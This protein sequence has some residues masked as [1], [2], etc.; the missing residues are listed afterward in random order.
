MGGE[1]LL[2]CVLAAS[3]AGGTAGVTWLPRGL[4]RWGGSKLLPLCCVLAAFSVGRTAGGC[5]VALAATGELKTIRSYC[6]YLGEGEI[7]QSDFFIPSNYIN[8]Q[9][10]EMPSYLRAYP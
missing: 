9:N 2:R 8:A 10:K 7:A 4:C 3:S 1:L 6:E 5:L